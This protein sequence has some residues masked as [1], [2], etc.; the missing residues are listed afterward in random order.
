MS[1]PDK[2]TLSSQKVRFN[3]LLKLI[4]D[5]PSKQKTQ[6]IK[7]VLSY[8]NIKELRQIEDKLSEWWRESVQEAHQRDR[9][10]QWLI[11]KEE[12]GE[13]K[14]PVSAKHIDLFYI[15]E[16][17]LNS[18]IYYRVRWWQDGQN[19]TK[20]VPATLSKELSLLLLSTNPHPTI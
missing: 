8:M 16:N 13:F 5:L 2:V 11:E 19:V 20:H 10:R 9:I 6:L 3:T 18:G 15:D 17:R 7:E 12:T 14:L 4:K 1:L